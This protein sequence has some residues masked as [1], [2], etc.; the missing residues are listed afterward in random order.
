MKNNIKSFVLGFFVCAMISA[1]TVYATNSS[2]I[3]VYFK[4][5]NYVFNGV[6]KVP[7][8]TGQGFIYKGTTYVPL[9]F[10]SESLNK[11]VSWNGETGTIRVSDNPGEF[12][13]DDL[14]I[15][16]T[17]SNSIISLGMPKEEVEQKLGKPI[18]V[19]F[20]EIYNYNGLEIFYRDAKVAGLIVKAGENNTNRYRTNKNLGLGNKLSEVLSNYGNG[21]VDESFNQVAVTYLFSKENDKLIK[22]GSTEKIKDRLSGAYSVSF[23]FF[24]NSNKT[25][26]MIL[27]GDFQF[28]YL[29]Q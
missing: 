8:S 9:R 21:I 2:Q 5:L 24:D 22:V 29:T 1:T 13:L 19:N 4:K 25:I 11:E 15:T 26:S 23:S 6:E 20:E 14:S 10:I 7:D 17:L 27:I 12:V 16:D 3:E 28:A 18:D